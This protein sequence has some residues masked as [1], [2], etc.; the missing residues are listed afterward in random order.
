M[1]TMCVWSALQ[2]NVPQR[3]KYNSFT[4]LQNVITQTDLALSYLSIC[5]STFK[6]CF[7]WAKWLIVT[8][9]ES[10]SLTQL[11]RRMCGP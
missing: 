10:G 6:A 5:S 2:C 11:T 1:E 4:V 8:F 9:C 3:Q 7:S